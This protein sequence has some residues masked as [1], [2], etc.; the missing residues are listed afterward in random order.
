[1]YVGYPLAASSTIS[2]EKIG[3]VRFFPTGLEESSHTYAMVTLSER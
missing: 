2:M 3:N 1:M